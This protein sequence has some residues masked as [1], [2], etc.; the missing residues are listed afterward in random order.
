MTLLE[1]LRNQL[2]GEASSQIGAQVGLGKEDTRKAIDSALP[3]L[4]AA[5][6]GNA[7]KKDGAAGLARA[8]EQDHD[9]SILDDLG[10]FLSRGETRNG[11]GILKHA[12]GTRRPAVETAVAQQ[13]G[14]DSRAVSGLLPLLAPVI[15][16]ALGREKRKAGLDPAGLANMLAGEGKKAKEMAP[17]GLGLLESLLD[18]EGDGLD[19]GDMVDAGKKLLGGFLGRQR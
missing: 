15:M 14:L 8:L 4:M 10:G 19:A 6:A 1:L 11:E 7:R 13:T 2:D 12:L 18:D 9:G 5:L 16:G 3:T 17:G